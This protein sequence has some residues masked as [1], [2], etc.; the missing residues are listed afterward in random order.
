MHLLRLGPAG[1]ERPAV[2]A[3]DGA[4]YDLSSLTAD[5]DGD[6]PRR[7]RH[8][9]GAR[10]AGRGGL[11]DRLDPHGLRVGPP[12][13][14]PGAVSAS[15]STTP[16]TPPSRAVRRRTTPVVFFKHPE[17]GRR[18]L[19]R[20]AASRAGAT[21]VDWEVELAVVI[22]RRGPL[23]RVAR[24][25]RW[26]TSPATRSPTTSPSATSSW[27]TRA[28]SGRRASAARRSTRSARGCPGRR[29]R[30]P[31]A[32]R[33]ALVGQR[34]AAP[35]LDHRRHDLLGRP[36]G[37]APVRSSWCSTPATC[38]N[39]GTPQ[40]VALSGRFPYLAPGDVVELEVDGLGRQRQVLVGV[41]A[42]RR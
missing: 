19:R 24:P 25:T 8:R 38:I 34:R 27:T 1:S 13:A 11:P 29:G 22:G 40:G 39:T 32:A 21:Q 26:R 33:A 14:R 3:G 9:P 10:R 28:A 30:R 12:V 20:R 31:A 42:A 16:R 4:V 37:L 5:I 6:V 36:P 41:T 7:R 35:G 18:R 15:G 23:P 2:R 17:H